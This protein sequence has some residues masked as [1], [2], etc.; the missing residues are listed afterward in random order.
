MAYFYLWISEKWG[1]RPGTF[2]WTRDSSQ[3]LYTGP[4]AQES[5]PTSKVGPGTLKMGFKTQNGTR[6]A[7][8]LSYST[9][10]SD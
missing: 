10:R 5:R 7:E 3:R 8:Q 2:D 6:N 4:D 1:P 9:K